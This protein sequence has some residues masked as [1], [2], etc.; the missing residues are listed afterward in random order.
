M[1]KDLEG[2]TIISLE[3]GCVEMEYSSAT[4]QFL[5]RQFM[6][7]R[8]G[9][10]FAHCTEE[11]WSDVSAKLLEAET[12]L[13]IKRHGVRHCSLVCGG[14]SEDVE[15]YLG[16]LLQVYNTSNFVDKPASRGNPSQERG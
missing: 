1:H 4:A 6:G 3:N 11:E 9:M 2:K 13:C 8:E 16:I 12:S 5:A 14:Y 15:E 7:L 10:A